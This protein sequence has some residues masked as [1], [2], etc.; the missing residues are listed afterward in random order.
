MIMRRKEEEWASG[1][2]FMSGN[3][4]R[5]GYCKGRRKCKLATQWWEADTGGG[6]GAGGLSV[7]NQVLF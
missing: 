2:L 5:W 3:L 4:E 6:S 1:A 7:Q